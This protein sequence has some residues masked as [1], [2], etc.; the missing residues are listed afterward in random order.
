MRVAVGCLGE[1]DEIEQLERAAVAIGAVLL[2]HP[3]AELDVAHRGHVREEAVGLE[4]H[5]DVATVRRYVGHVL[6]VDHHPPRGRPVEPSD[7]PERGR[8]AAA[9]R[10][11]QRDE[12]ARRD[13][14]ID[15][16]EGDDLPEPAVQLLQLDVGHV[17][18]L[19]FGYRCLLSTADRQERQHRRPRD[20][21]REQR[22]RPRRIRLVLVD[23]LDV[24][25]E[26][27]ELRPGSRSC[28]RPSRSP[29]SGTSRRA[30]PP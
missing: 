14:E 26:R 27:V 23:V 20:P 19:P 16:G 11:E 3:E 22:D 5:A 15:P 7:E 30:P 2:A 25:G 29:A 13:V 10:P 9:G 8:L 12:L 28:T 18:F 6:A 1:A 4:D 24:D 21:E 17:L